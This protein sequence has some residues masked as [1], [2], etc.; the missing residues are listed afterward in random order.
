MNQQHNI[1]LRQLH[2]EENHVKKLKS[3]TIGQK[4]EPVL[5]KKKPFQQQKNSFSKQTNPTPN[6]LD[7]SK[8]YQNTLKQIFILIVD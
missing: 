3:L 8:G 4:K 5:T 7:G 1:K 2:A 6:G